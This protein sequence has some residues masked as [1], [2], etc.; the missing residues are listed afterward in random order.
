[1]GNTY[2]RELASVW[3]HEK[4]A[5]H[6]GDSFSSPV[7]MRM[8]RILLENGELKKSSL[9]SKAGLNYKVCTKYIGFLSR[10]NWI[11]I[12]SDDQGVRI[13]IP[14]EGIE[15]LRKLESNDS[16]TAKQIPGDGS[17]KLLEYTVPAKAKKSQDRS[18]SAANKKTIVIID[19]DE[20]ALAT[21]STFLEND[22]NIRTLTFSDSKKALEYLTLHSDACHLVLLDI[23]MPEMSGLR[24]HQAL[25]ALN[26]RT[27]IIFLS[28]L[29]AGPEISEL[30][31]DSRLGI[32]NF[33]RKPV[34]RA[35]FIDT[36]T[37]ALF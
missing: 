9:C 2:Y 34:S 4:M 14:A 13:S 36:V 33:L 16:E 5:N 22:K 6:E 1:M 23:R 12:K 35:N 17:T 8:L 32:K 37:R 20:N 3:H 29:D 31:P 21:Y 26:P 19:D 28:S 7:I 18:G 25:K 15:N 27:A 24:I 11:Q 10:L 30:Y